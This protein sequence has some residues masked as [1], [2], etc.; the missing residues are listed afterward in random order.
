MLLLLFIYISV[1][2]IILFTLLHLFVLADGDY[3]SI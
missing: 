3:F 2:N 1:D